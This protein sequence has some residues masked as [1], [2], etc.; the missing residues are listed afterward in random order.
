MGFIH[1]KLEDYENYL[2]EMLLEK[3][4][5]KMKR[6]TEKLETLKKSVEYAKADIHHLFQNGFTYDDKHKKYTKEENIDYGKY[7]GKY[8]I[9][10]SFPESYPRSPPIVCFKPLFKGK[11]SEHIMD[12]DGNGKV[13]IAKAEG[14]FPNTYWQSWMNARGALMLAYSIV[15]DE[16][17][18]TKGSRREVP[19]KGSI[20]ENVSKLVSKDKF[21]ENFMKKNGITDIDR[22]FTWGELAFK[23]AQKG[24]KARS[25][26]I[27]YYQGLKDG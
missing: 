11:I 23:I 2:A 7:P 8:R 19:I 10:V 12:A 1:N 24:Q 27:K 13:C 4:L 20:F 26:L 21:I 25:E 14:S 17:K 3:G 9:S 16:Y 18:R 5:G 22:T 15:T 6:E